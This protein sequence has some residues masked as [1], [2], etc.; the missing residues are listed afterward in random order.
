MSNHPIATATRGLNVKQLALTGLMT[1]VLCILGPLSLNIPISPVP[2]SL[3]FLGIYFICSVL[4]MKLGTL[5]VVV[6]I[7]LGLAGL[8]VFTGF[9]GGPGK[10]FG[11]TGGYI[12]GY[13]F[14]ALLCGLGVDKGKGRLLPTL[15]G[16]ILGSV[17]GYLFGTVWL[18]RQQSIGFVQALFLGVI[19]YIPVDIVKLAVG[20]AVGSRLRRR[21]LQAGLLVPAQA[22]VKV[23]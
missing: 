23:S 2:I 7:L 8:P 6:Y 9:T 3:G 21:L 10:L 11:P 14:M 19:P 22:P 15:A 4:G 13:T 20:V 16:M 5:S 17:V 18:A 12:I 1:A